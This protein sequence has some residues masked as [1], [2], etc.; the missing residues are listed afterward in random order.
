MAALCS[1]ALLAW[2]R[3]LRS[4]RAGAALLA[5]AC[6]GAA[7]A[8]LQKGAAF[9]VLLLAGTFLAASSSHPW[10]ATT[11]GSLLFAGAAAGRSAAFPVRLPRAPRRT[12]LSA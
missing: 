5:G 12:R 4:G 3:Y 6:A 10:R 2:L 1:A 11:R 7:T 9:S 8:T